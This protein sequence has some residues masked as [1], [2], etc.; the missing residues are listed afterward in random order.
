MEDLSGHLVHGVVG[1]SLGLRVSGEWLVVS[2]LLSLENVWTDIIVSIPFLYIGGTARVP[3]WVSRVIFKHSDTVMKL[4]VLNKSIDYFP[5]PRKTSYTKRRTMT[6]RMDIT[7]EDHRYIQK[8]NN[9]C[10]KNTSTQAD[11]E[12]SYITKP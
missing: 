12:P 6:I 5:H 4:S 11:K 8:Q 7:L 3:F 10:R 1:V 9:T 2:I